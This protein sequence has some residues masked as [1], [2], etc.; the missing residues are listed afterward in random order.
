M[1]VCA[2]AYFVEYSLNHRGL[3][4]NKVCTAIPPDI[5]LDPLELEFSGLTEK[6]KK[7]SWCFFIFVS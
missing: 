5:L 2:D 6:K 3:E 1:R 4:P 7:R